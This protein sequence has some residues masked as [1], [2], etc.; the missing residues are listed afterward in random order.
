MRLCTIKLLAVKLC[1]MK[2]YAVRLCAV[3]LDSQTIIF[4]LSSLAIYMIS[5]KPSSHWHRWGYVVGLIS[6]IPWFYYTYT[7][8]QYKILATTLLFTV[9]WANGIRNYWFRGE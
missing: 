5:Q 8:G 2:L 1:A 4:I 7:T 6:Q 9:S 3:R